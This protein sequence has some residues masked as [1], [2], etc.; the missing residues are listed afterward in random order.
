[1]QVQRRCRC[2]GGGEEVKRCRCRGA[3][4]QRC[5]GAEVMQRL[6]CRGHEELVMQRCRCS[7]CSRC[8]RCSRC[9]RC[10]RRRG[11]EMQW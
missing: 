1:M 10:S 6:S 11:A 3:E 8:N 7:R 2:R 9:S 5:T 4:V